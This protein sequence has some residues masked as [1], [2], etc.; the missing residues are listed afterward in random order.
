MVDKV[1]SHLSLGCL[2]LSDLG[3]G[4]SLDTL[5]YIGGN[6]SSHGHK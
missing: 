5:I 2:C 1:P 3:L 6:I 4:V